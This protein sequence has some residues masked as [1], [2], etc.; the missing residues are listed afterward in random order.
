M[1]RR[2]YRDRTTV[3][4]AQ[5]MMTYVAW[6]GLL[7]FGFCFQRTMQPTHQTNHATMQPCNY[8]RNQSWYIG[9]RMISHEETTLSAAAAG[10]AKLHGGQTKFVCPNSCPQCDNIMAACVI[11][12]T[13]PQAL[14]DQECFAECV[15]GAPK[16][17]A[18]R[19]SPRC[20]VHTSSCECY[21]RLK[22]AN[23][24]PDVILKI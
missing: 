21:H 19:L 10:A 20:I 23:E 16:R 7:C 5:Y 3:V 11:C 2:G 8:A 24:R 15:L 14:Y 6:R 13:K 18:Q 4:C 22:S 1:R 17:A 12:Q 9:L